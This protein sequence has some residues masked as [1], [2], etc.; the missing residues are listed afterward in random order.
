VTRQA[1]EGS[2]LIPLFFGILGGIVAYIGV[3]DD[4]KKMA[5]N[6]LMFGVV[7]TIILIGIYL[8]ILAVVLTQY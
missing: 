1:Q 7:W 8:C 4:D 2:N 6:L 5:N 3:K